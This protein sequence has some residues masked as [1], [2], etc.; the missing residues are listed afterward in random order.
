MRSLKYTV[1]GCRLPI[2]FRTSISILPYHESLPVPRDVL[3]LSLGLNC[4]RVFP[5]FDDLLREVHSHNMAKGASHTPYFMTIF[6]NFAKVYS[7]FTT[8]N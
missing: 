1:L 6:L 5:Q 3:P 4:F 2:S 7:D 8:P